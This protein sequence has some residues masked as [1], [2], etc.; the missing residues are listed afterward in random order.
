MFSSDELL[1]AAAS[2]V[3]HFY[4]LSVLSFAWQCLLTTAVAALRNLPVIRKTCISKA[5]EILFNRGRPAVTKV[6][7]LGLCIVEESDDIGAV[8][9]SLQADEADA[10]VDLFLLC[11]PVSCIWKGEEVRTMAM[12][13]KLRFSSLSLF[14]MS[15]KVACGT[16]LE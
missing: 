10:V 6:C 5:F 13:K 4:S 16:A 3:S 12:R 15:T 14:S 2:S 7:T 11:M 1:L 8:Q 9:F